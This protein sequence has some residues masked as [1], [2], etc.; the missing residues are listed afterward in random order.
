VILSANIPHYSYIFFVTDT[1]PQNTVRSIHESRHGICDDGEQAPATANAT[2]PDTIRVP[3]KP[4]SVKVCRSIRGRG[5]ST[6]PSGS[7]EKEVVDA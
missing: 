6:C 1:I 7:V 5:R 4:G 2:I 3:K